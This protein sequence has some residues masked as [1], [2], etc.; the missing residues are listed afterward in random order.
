MEGRENK[1]T[2]SCG[3]DVFFPTSPMAKNLCHTERGMAER[4]LN[5][6]VACEGCC[7]G[8]V[9]S[10]AFLSFKGSVKLPC[11]DIHM[12]GKL[13]HDG[14]RQESSAMKEIVDEFDPRGSFL[15]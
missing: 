1:S 8:A 10:P 15:P 13:A 6:L 7:A 12:M 4:W 2:L 11:Y 5:S 3:R 14:P 9:S